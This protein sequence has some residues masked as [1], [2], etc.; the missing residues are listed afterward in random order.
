MPEDWCGPVTLTVNLPKETTFD[1]V[2]LKE[3]IELGQRIE[4]FAIDAWLDGQWNQIT[5]GSTVGHKRILNVPQTRTSKLRLRI[6]ESRVC[7][8]LEQFGIFFRGDSSSTANL[9]ESNKLT[10]QSKSP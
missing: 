1:L 3:H 5:A 9:A 6:M 7:P 8:T 2:S 4:S 10:S